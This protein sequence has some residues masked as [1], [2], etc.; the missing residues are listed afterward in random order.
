MM[1]HD[2]YAYVDVALQAPP[3]PDYVSGPEHPPSHAYVPKF[4]LE[5]VYLEFK[6]PEDDVLL[7]EEQPLPAADDKEEEAS[8]DDAD[9]D[10]EDED[11]D[12]EEDKHTTLADSIPP[13][14]YRVTARMS[15]QSQTPISLPSETKVTRLL[16]IPTP[17]PSPLSSLSS[18]LPQIL[19]P[20]PQILSP[21]IPI[22]PP[23]LPTSLTYSLG[24]RAAMIRLR[25][26]ADIPEVTLPPRKRLCVAL[27]SRFE[28]SESS[29]TPTARP[30]GGFRAYYGFFGTLD[31]EI[32]QD[33]N[34]IYRRLDDAQDDRL[35]MSGQLNMLHRD[36]R[37]YAHTARL[38]K[39]EARLS[40]KAW[41]QSMDASDTTRA[42]VMSLRTTVTTRSTPATTTTTTTT[43][44]TNAQ[45]KALIDQGVAYALAAHDVDRSRN[46]K[47]SHNSRTS[48]RRHAP[49]A[50]EYTYQ[51]FM[52][53]KPLYFKG[54]KEVVNLTQWFER[55]ETAFHISNC[56]VENQINFAICTLLGSALTWWNFHVKT[57][58]PD[59]AYA[60]TWT[61]LKKDDQQEL[62]LMCARMFPEESDKIEREVLSRYALN[63]TITMMVR[64]LQNSTSAIGHLA[65]DCRSP[66][67]ANTAN[68]QRGTRTGLKVAY[69]ECGVQ[70]HLKRE[71]PNLKNNNR[72][73][74]GGNG[75]AQAKVLIIHGDGSK[76]GNETR[77]NI[78][79]YTK[80]QNYMLKGCHVFL[81]HVTIKETED[82]SEK[83]RLEDVPIVQDFPKVF[84]EDLQGLPLTQKV[85][86]Q[87]D[88]IPGAALVART[89]Y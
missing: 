83:K 29:S 72:S 45:L 2:P 13:P 36:R 61:N 14:V 19:S 60:M 82:K 58:G 86:F 15:V 76:Q 39:S 32:R 23:P 24:Y 66:I 41:V 10:E 59:V 26:E 25:A 75:N 89:P 8:E 57:I 44:V 31:D 79:S 65:R 52:K 9:E 33:T 88:Y 6:P 46:V 11:E 4:V 85:E 5:P 81:A 47:D 69:F 21:P 38:I 1:P 73:N 48:V 53:C 67:N 84:P 20:L 63:A 78:I 7:A 71:C 34:E 55:M 54:T 18:P 22:S 64:V 43:P 50:R 40:C 77:L 30:I 70:R 62:A 80:T 27:G 68:N 87:I 28:V 16:D 37:A 42:K 12:E 51:D 17:P 3:S 35:L 74:Q 49:P 56:N